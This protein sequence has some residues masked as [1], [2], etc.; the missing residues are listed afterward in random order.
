MYYIYCIRIFPSF[1]AGARH[2]CILICPRQM[3]LHLDIPETIVFQ[4]RKCLS[5][6]LQ[7]L[8]WSTKVWTM[9]HLSMSWVFSSFRDSMK[10]Y[11]LVQLIW[12]WSCWNLCEAAL[13]LS[14]IWNSFHST[15][16][17]TIHLMELIRPQ[18]LPY[19]LLIFTLF[20][21]TCLIVRE[22]SII[23]KSNQLSTPFKMD[24]KNKNSSQ[25]Y[26]IHPLIVSTSPFIYPFQ[27][28]RILI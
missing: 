19:Y 27:I 21:H 16:S 22:S 24:C 1:A 11:V 3:H 12:Q 20:L 13:R 25:P 9:A 14:R 18:F 6:F 7:L 26:H 15:R 2:S 4:G 28:C 10:F 5:T 8:Q 23:N 17:S